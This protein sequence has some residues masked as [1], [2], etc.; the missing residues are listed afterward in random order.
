MQLGDRLGEFLFEAGLSVEAAAARL[1]RSPRYIEALTTGLLQPDED[2]FDGLCQ[3][4]SKS[5]S[6]L[7]SVRDWTVMESR[8]RL[9]RYCE[10]TGRTADE[11]VVLAIRG[12][13][14]ARMPGR[15]I[16]EAE[17]ASLYEQAVGSQFELALG[18]SPVQ[19]IQLRAAPSPRESTE[20]PCHRCGT[21]NGLFS[22]RCRNCGTLL[23]D[24]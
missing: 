17:W 24:D 5:R 14:P 12:G 10:Q 21:P 11:M 6:E 13:V 18:D 8:Q 23:T 7:A 19:G 15:V 16:T 9:R 4:L 22:P 2:T 3:L 1:D 20:L